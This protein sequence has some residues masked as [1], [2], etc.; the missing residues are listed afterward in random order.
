MPDTVLSTWHPEDIEVLEKRS[1]EPD[2]LNLKLNS[3]I[4][5]EKVT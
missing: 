1:L 4:K 5:P 3:A 2:L